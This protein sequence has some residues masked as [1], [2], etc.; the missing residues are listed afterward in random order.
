MALGIFQ[1]RYAQYD[2]TGLQSRVVSHVGLAG[3]GKKWESLW[4]GG[5]TGRTRDTQDT[6]KGGRWGVRSNIGDMSADT[7][8]T[9]VKRHVNQGHLTLCFKVL[10]RLLPKIPG[11][12][13]W[14][15]E[16]M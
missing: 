9:K 6:A 14:V 16:F 13:T 8:D 15:C 4:K 2:G 11:V 12:F 7:W 1:T 5:H 10:R 3:S